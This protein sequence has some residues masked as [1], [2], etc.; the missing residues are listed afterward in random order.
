MDSPGLSCPVLGRF[1]WLVTC[2]LVL[3]SSFRFVQPLLL[4]IMRT[5]RQSGPHIFCHIG[6]ILE[7]PGSFNDHPSAA[8][9]YGGDNNNQH[10]L[11]I[12]LLIVFLLPFS[13]ELLQEWVS[14]L[15]GNFGTTYWLNMCVASHDAIYE[16]LLRFVSRVFRFN[17]RVGLAVGWSFWERD[18]DKRRKVKCLLRRAYFGSLC[19]LYSARWKAAFSEEGRTWYFICVC[20]RMV[21]KW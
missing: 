1:C 12:L 20:E 4:I 21:V 2:E 7:I 11:R 14:F 19:W 16:S 6:G 18:T 10:C 13:R 15:A 3:P 5:Y 17:S 8:E 9:Q